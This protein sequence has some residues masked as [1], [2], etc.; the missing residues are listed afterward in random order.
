VRVHIFADAFLWL[1]RQ[2]SSFNNAFG[3]EKVKLAMYLL[4]F[5]TRDPSKE[6]FMMCD[7]IKKFSVMSDWYTT[8]AIFYFCRLFTEQTKYLSYSRNSLLFIIISFK[9]KIR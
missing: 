3:V 6:F 8:F 7:L 1:N 2:S 9:H 5:V 4:L